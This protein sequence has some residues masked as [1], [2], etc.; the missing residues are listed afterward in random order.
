MPST[1]AGNEASAIRAARANQTAAIAAGDLDRVA[2][3]WTE[4]ITIRRGLGH[5]VEGIAAARAILL[6][7]GA[8]SHRI[9]YR[10]V[11][12]RV[13]VSAAWPLAFEEG[14]WTGHLGSAAGTVVIGGRYA[15]QWV[16]R[17]GGWLIRSEVFVA[18]TAD[19]IGRDFAAL[20]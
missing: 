3:F 18:L 17:A 7:A 20:A 4:D 2:A 8:A 11:S 19:G 6:P 9:V 14:D 1:T 15:A 13:D 10:R 5:P 16:K 12:T